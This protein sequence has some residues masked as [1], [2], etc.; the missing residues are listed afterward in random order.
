VPR[1]RQIDKVLGCNL[2]AMRK[3]SRRGVCGERVG[4]ER[5]MFSG[6]NAL[7]DAIC[8]RSSCHPDRYSTFN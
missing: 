2:R 4:W 6:F 8:N 1:S 5:A 3:V 7:L